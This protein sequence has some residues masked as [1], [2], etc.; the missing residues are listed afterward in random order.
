M[1]S[2]CNQRVTPTPIREDAFICRKSPADFDVN[3]YRKSTGEL[4][5]GKSAAK[6]SRVLPVVATDLNGYSLPNISASDTLGS[7]LS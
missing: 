7:V 1:V 4:V 2:A 6:Y 5:V 3:V